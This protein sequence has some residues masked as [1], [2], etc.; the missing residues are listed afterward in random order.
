MRET[1]ARQLLVAEARRLRLLHD[2]VADDVATT[3]AD[4]DGRPTSDV[5][6]PSAG[7]VTLEHEVEESLRMAVDDERAEV[8]FALA[9]LDTGTFGMCVACG[10]PIPDARL[11]VVP[12]ARFCVAC[13]A[14]GE[15]WAGPGLPLV[16]SILRAALREVEGWA[17]EGPDEDDLVVPG[18]EEGAVHRTPPSGPPRHVVG[19]PER[20]TS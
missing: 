16:D 13:E 1:R 2:V 9:R 3:R 5:H 11:E 12:A 15:R 6:G 17:D 8:A 19:A 4:A 18:P 20:S 14:V 7:A 10:G